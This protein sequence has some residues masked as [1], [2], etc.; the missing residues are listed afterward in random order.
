MAT[1][2]RKPTKVSLY[3]HP[4]SKLWYWRYI[5]GKSQKIVDESTGK[6]KYKP[7]KE[8]VYITDFEW[9][10]EPKNARERQ[11]NKET[12]QE[13]ELLLKEKQ[14]EIK[15]GKYSLLA[16]AVNDRNVFDDFVDYY[17]NKDYQ[18]RTRLQHESILYHL[19]KYS[20]VELLAYSDITVEFMEGFLDYLNE[21]GTARLGKALASTSVAN[22]FNK[23]KVFLGVMVDK[24]YLKSHPAQKVVAKKGKP[25]RKVSLT[26]EELQQL[27]KTECPN[28]VLR[29][30]FLFSC[31]SGQAVAECTAMEWRDIEESNGSYTLIGTRVKTNS[32]YRIALSP[33]AV[34]VL[35]ERK[36]EHDK[37]FRGFKYSANNNRHLIDW[38]RAAGI[39]KHITPHAARHTFARLWWENP[40]NGKDI[41]VLMQILDHKDVTTTQRYL[42]SLIGSATAMP[43]PSIGDFEV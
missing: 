36:G 19:R 11:V 18:K 31:L 7:N 28:P 35:G 14:V 43:T 9:Y 5:F 26:K 30:F 10:P 12:E 29:K 22:Y 34:K 15:K 33:T 2:K 6:V 16:K 40:A 4:V 41:L 21:E 39:T 32:D 17:T 3:Y 37:V 38:C 25:K 1:L 27:I 20:G 24:G 42:S 8:D 23:F 13:L